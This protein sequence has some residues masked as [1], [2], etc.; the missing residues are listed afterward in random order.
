MTPF[1]TSR[2]DPG[3]RTTGLD[4]HVNLGLVAPKKRVVMGG[5]F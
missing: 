5:R 3:R 2:P 1:A 4:V